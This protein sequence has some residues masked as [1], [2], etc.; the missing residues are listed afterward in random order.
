MVRNLDEDVPGVERLTT[1]DKLGALDIGRL[2]SLVYDEARVKGAHRAKRRRYVLRR[3][4]QQ[5]RFKGMM[6]QPPQ[7]ILHLG[8]AT[9]NVLN[10][11]KWDAVGPIDG[12][13]RIEVGRMYDERGLLP[14]HRN[15]FAPLS[16]EVPAAPPPLHRN[17]RPKNLAWRSES[18]P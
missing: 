7:Y 15:P 16:A 3:I 4:S 5:Q 10:A 9:N 12:S 18:K 8:W 11:G 17:R 1:V 2:V 6:P 14:R 13:R